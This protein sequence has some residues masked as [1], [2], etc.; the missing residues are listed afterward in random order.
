MKKKKRKYRR[1]NQ[2][3]TDKATVDT[4]EQHQKDY[5]VNQQRRAFPCTS[6]TPEPVVLS[7]GKRTIKIAQ[8]TTLREL[9][10]MGVQVRLE[11]DAPVLPLDPSDKD[12]SVNI[13]KNE[14]FI[15]KRF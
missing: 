3:V 11:P 9:A 6:A 10:K 1:R 12:L 13:S 5:A 8:S 15:R 4:W 2:R 7:N 14:I